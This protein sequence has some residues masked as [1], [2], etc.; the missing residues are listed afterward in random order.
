MTTTQKIILSVGIATTIVGGWFIYLY[1]KTF[2]PT[3]ASLSIPVQIDIDNTKTYADNSVSDIQSQIDSDWQDAVIIDGVTF[4]K[5]KGDGRYFDDNGN[6]YDDQEDT[7]E[8]VAGKQTYIDPST[9]TYGS[10]DD[11]GNF[12]ND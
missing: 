8:S 5:G 7:M 6:A 3:S 9:V 11:M 4:I 1:L 12:I 2:H 10:I